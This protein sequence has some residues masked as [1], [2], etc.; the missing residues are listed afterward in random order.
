MEKRGNKRTLKSIYFVF[1][2]FAPLCYLCSLWM[3]NVLN[4]TYHVQNKKNIR[5]SCLGNRTNTGYLKNLPDTTLDIRP[6]AGYWRNAES[7]QS[8]TMNSLNLSKE[9]KSQITLIHLMAYF[10]LFIKVFLDFDSEY[11]G[12]KAGRRMMSLGHYK[13]IQAHPIYIYIYIYPNTTL[14]GEGGINLA[15]FKTIFKLNS[16]SSYLYF[17]WIKMQKN[18]NCHPFPPPS[19]PLPREILN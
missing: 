9:L 7:G 13:Y 6:D 2:L 10:F 12:V 18:T 14:G 15:S 4:L 19:L 8:Q 3:L 1:Y 16:Q 11:G 5:I 17:L